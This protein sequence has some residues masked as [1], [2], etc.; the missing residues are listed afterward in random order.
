MDTRDERGFSGFVCGFDNRIVAGVLD[1][2]GTY[3]LAVLLF[4]LLVGYSK[5]S[6]YQGIVS[7]RSFSLTGAHDGRRSA[8]YNRN[9]TRYILS[10]QQI[11]RSY[12]HSLLY[13][14]ET[15]MHG[16]YT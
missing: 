9:S 7:P 16:S 13:L 8:F 4:K 3:G 10:K 11:T 6:F 1:V 14:R 12:S 2:A 15:D 5:F